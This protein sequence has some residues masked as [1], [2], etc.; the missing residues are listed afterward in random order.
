MRSGL[1]KIVD[2]YKEHK[3]TLAS[4]MVAWPLS[5]AA[6]AYSTHFA[7]DPVAAV[8]LSSLV[9]QATYWPTFIA[10]KVVGDRKQFTSEGKVQWNTVRRKVGEYASW[11]GAGEVVYSTV[12][13]AV[14]GGLRAL[15][16][17]DAE[18]SAYTDLAA[19]SAYTLMMPFIQNAIYRF[20][21]AVDDRVTKPIV[22]YIRKV[23]DVF[24]HRDG[25]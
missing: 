15:G 21:Q 14:M 18:S 20:N 11:W 5:T 16:V 23:A 19:G 3:S 10:G 25:C 1:E 2:Y 4:Q 12:R 8:A 9:A 7:D 24:T 17:A 6:A 22:A 13:S